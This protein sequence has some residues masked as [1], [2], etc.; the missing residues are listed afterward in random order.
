MFNLLAVYFNDETFVNKLNI[1]K[2]IKVTKT[3]KRLHQSPE[4][5]FRF[6]NGQ[7]HKKCAEVVGFQE[8]HGKIKCKK[9]AE[10]AFTQ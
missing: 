10:S 5:A 8:T 9:N 7:N 3:K 1:L 4:G 2:G 6:M